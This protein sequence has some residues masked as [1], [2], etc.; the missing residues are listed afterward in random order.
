MVTDGVVHVA[1]YELMSTQV[2]TG[3]GAEVAPAS[4]HGA[5][6]ALSSKKVTVAAPQTTPL[7]EEQAHA[8]HASGGWVGLAF[9]S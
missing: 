8:E 5:V 9:P 6:Q 3:S 7:A 2:P 4:A 1:V